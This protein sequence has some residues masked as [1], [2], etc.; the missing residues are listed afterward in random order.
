MPKAASEPIST[1]LE[2][3]ERITEILFGVIM[4]LTFTC[5]LA[6]TADQLQVHAML[7]G[8]LGC[9]L[10]WGAIDAGVYVLTR[11]NIEGRAIATVRQ[12]R[13]ADDG[14]VARQILGSSLHPLLA[15]AL[16]KDQMELIRQNL[17]QMP[18]PP[19]HF[20]LTKRD[21]R[22]AG[23]LC[24]LC[25]FSTFPIAL[26]FVFVSETYRRCVFPMPLP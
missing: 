4:T 22:A 10:A 25:F 26:P 9:N 8:A 17:R 18:E 20:N 19:E 11:I 21:W 1:L 2:P 12:I 6:V 23:R 14:N 7:F 3:M 15:S 24:L 13:E 5:T 16:S